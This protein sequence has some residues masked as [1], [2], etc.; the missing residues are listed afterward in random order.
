MKSVLISGGS[1]LVGTRLTQLLEAKGYAVAHISRRPKTDVKTV[2]WNVDKMSLDPL[3]IEP[4]DH[5]I[6]LAGAGIVDKKW[7]EHR[8]KEIIESRT[9]STKLLQQAISQNSQKPKS[10]VSASAVGFYGFVTEER[11]YT[12]TDQAGDD[13]LGETCELWE[14][15]ID[16]IADL[17]IPTSK[18]RIGIVLSKEGGALKEMARPIQF[19]FGAALGSGK[20]YIPWIHIDDLCKLF[21]YAMEHRLE[22]AFNATA[23]EAINNKEF[24][25]TLAAVLKKPLWLPNV[26]AF[27][28]KILL[29][30]RALLVL[31]GSRVSSEKIEK[32]GFTF[33]HKKLKETLEKIYS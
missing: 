26:P 16:K 6:N 30:E 17:G 14:E 3:A 31:E 25:K 12:E 9:Q 5:I 2:V 28:M 7:T 15:E 18:I 1:G 10:F 21:I 33:T 13:F 29:G 8:K 32:H 20:Q 24:T 23:A 11:I 22:G 19:G 27:F 4:F